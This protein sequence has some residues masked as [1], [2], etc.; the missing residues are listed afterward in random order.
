V[1]VGVP[2]CG[3]T[4]WYHLL[5]AHPGVTGLQKEPYFFL[6]DERW[7]APDDATIAAYHELFPRPPGALA[8]EWSPGYLQH[9][10]MPAVLRRAAPD[11]KILVMLRDP[12]ERYRSSVT[13]LSTRQRGPLTSLRAYIQG[14]YATQLEWLYARF[15][16]EQ[17]LVL[18]LER[19]TSE[20]E[21]ELARTFRFLGLGDDF[22]PADAARPVH[23]TK[24]QKVELDATL[25]AE[26]TR[27]YEPEVSR[28]PPLAP[29]VDV[30]RWTNFRHLVR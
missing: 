2:K 15:P 20:P 25:R 30:S 11:A 26:L 14:C 3:T 13:V 18:Q 10:W 16:P 21:A 28:L 6:K 9:F 4:W 22:V 12:V 1:G 29:D 24:M 23:E 27:A 7:P 19:C 17:V 5:C 8:G